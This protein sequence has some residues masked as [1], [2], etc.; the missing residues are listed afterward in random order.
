MG[1]GAFHQ[2]AFRHFL[3][4]CGVL[5]KCGISPNCNSPD[6]ISPNL[7]IIK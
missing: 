5:K 3:K 2:V 1:C 7:R 4:A 6:C